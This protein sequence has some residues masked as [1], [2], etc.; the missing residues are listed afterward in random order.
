MLATGSRPGPGG[1]GAQAAAP[2]KGGSGTRMIEGMKKK[3]QPV[4]PKLQEMADWLD[5]LESGADSAGGEVQPCLCASI[6]TPLPL[7]P[8]N[9]IIYCARP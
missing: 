2:K 9:T 8:H 6:P 4:T 3:G 1:G 5:S 7:P